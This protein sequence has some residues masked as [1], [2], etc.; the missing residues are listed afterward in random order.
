MNPCE[1]VGGASFPGRFGGVT[2]TW[3]LM[4]AA[5]S[6]QGVEVMGRWP[7]ARRLLAAQADQ[8]WGRRFDVIADGRW[9]AGWGDL[10]RVEYV[11]NVVVR[12]VKAPDDVCEFRAPGAADLACLKAQI[13]AHSIPVE[14]RAM[15]PL[16]HRQSRG[17]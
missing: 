11:R 8:G 4:V 9:R 14:R 13:E 12:L 10:V 16:R 2:M 1:T 7:W 15:S 6:D 17:A 5:A 3:P